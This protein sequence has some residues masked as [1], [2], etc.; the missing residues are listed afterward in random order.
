MAEMLKTLPKME[1]PTVEPRIALDFD[2]EDGN[3]ITDITEE[4]KDFLV[5]E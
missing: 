2:D 1:I 5:D 4:E 3:M